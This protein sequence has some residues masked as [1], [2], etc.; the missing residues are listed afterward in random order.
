MGCSDNSGWI[1]SMSMLNMVLVI[2][3][4]TNGNSGGCAGCGEAI[5]GMIADGFNKV[6]DTMDILK[7]DPVKILESDNMIGVPMLMIVM[8]PLIVV[9]MFVLRIVLSMFDNRNDVYGVDSKL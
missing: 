8:L 2:L 9:G 6:F 4:V 7:N 1:V 3:I 5:G